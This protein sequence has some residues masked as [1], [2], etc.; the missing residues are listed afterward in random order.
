MKGQAALVFAGSAET[1]SPGM[2][3]AADALANAARKFRRGV[4]GDQTMARN[5]A[6]ILHRDNAAFTE[7]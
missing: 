2:L 1:G 4:C 5:N 7:A 6:G 3:A